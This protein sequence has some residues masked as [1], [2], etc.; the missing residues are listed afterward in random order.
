MKITTTNSLQLLNQNHQSDNYASPDENS[1]IRLK[2]EAKSYK[3]KFNAISSKL[4]SKH[5]LE[6]VEKR[7]LDREWIE[8]NCKSVD[9]KEATD[10]LGYTAKSSGILIEGANGQY[11]FKPDRP[12]SDRQGK[13]STKI[14]NSSR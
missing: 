1:S 3:S 12:W 14:S 2:T 10:L 6:C 8:A 13:K 5:T 4:N 9:V 7:G 11:Q